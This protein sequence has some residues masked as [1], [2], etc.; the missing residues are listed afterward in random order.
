MNPRLPLVLSLAV[1]AACAPD[2]D[3]ASAVRD[4][5]L[6]AFSSAAG[7]A[8]ALKAHIAAL[9]HD[10]MQGRAPGTA[11]GEAAAR[12]LERA[13]RQAGLERPPGQRRYRQ[14]VPLIGT[15][16]DPDG[17]EAAVG[18]DGGAT[19]PAADLLVSTGVV[20]P[21][22]EATAEVVFAGHGISRPDLEW[23][24]YASIEVEGRWV[25]LLGGVP[26][27]LAPRLEAGA[28]SREGQGDAKEE[29]ARRRGARGV[30]HLSSPGRSGFADTRRVYGSL[31]VL[32][33]GWGDRTEL[34]VVALLS[35]AWSDSLLRRLSVDRVAAAARPS[36]GGTPV[37]VSFAFDVA[38]RTFEAPNIVGVLPG[39]SDASILVTAH[40]DAYGIGAPD[41]EG[42]SIY[43]GARDN[44]AGTAGLVELARVFAGRETPPERTI[45]FVATTAEEA[46]TLGA[47]HVADH[48]EAYGAPAVNVNVD[49]LGFSPP[50]DDFAVFPVEGTDVIPV[51][52]RIAE[53]LGMRFSA[54]PWHTGMHFSFD[55]KRLLEAGVAGL[56]VWQGGAV[57]E[58]FR[59]TP[60]NAGG[61]IHTPND[62]YDP[63]WND[64]GLDQ[65]LALYL[66]I[67]DHW[68][69]G[70]PAPAV[71][72]DGPFAPGGR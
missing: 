14:A 13:F 7:S 24:D 8:P 33:P 22:V 61:P 9:A 50:T 27:A 6:A 52:E 43:N 39:R 45:W 55:T 23:D 32:M 28:D 48:L 69:A 4:E 62:E 5:P 19:I 30:V 68:A 29:E 3:A 46:N 31:E 12:Y 47:W 63:G 1:L 17:V 58:A 49:G 2:P 51:L 25:A 67:L 34:E 15:R 20:R 60:R 21:R 72:P 35:P 70:A 54:A 10:S 38:A 71:L 64:A 37:E 59:E 16:V 41:A 36:A 40:Y 26:E 53:P 42:D 66:A 18:G 57:R 65:H 56:T 11:G 44:A